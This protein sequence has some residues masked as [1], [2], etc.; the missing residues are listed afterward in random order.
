MVYGQNH[1]SVYNLKLYVLN[2]KNAF[3]L[4]KI[5]LSFIPKYF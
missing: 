1:T 5:N 2:K 4:F 3:V